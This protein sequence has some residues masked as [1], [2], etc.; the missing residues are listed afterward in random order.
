MR[1][2]FLAFLAVGAA[3]TVAADHEPQKS[4]KW[5]EL[6]TK[7]LRI[8]AQL[9]HAE[10]TNHEVLTPHSAQQNL[11]LTGGYTTGYAIAYATYLKTDT[12]CSGTPTQVTLRK[13]GTC[14]TSTSGGSTSSTFFT[15]DS[16]GFITKFTYPGSVCSG[17][18]ESSQIPKPSACACTAS[19]CNIQGGYSY[20]ATLPTLSGNVAASYYYT[21]GVTTCTGNY[22]YFNLY[23]LPTGATCSDSACSATDSSGTTYST[24]TCSAATTPALVPVTTGYLI[25][26]VMYDKTDKA[27]STPTGSTFIKLGGCFPIS[28]TAARMFVADSSGSLYYLYYASAT[29]AGTPTETSAAV[30]ARACACDATSCTTGFFYTTELPIP[31]VAYSVTTY[32]LGSDCT[33]APLMLVYTATSKCTPVA[34]TKMTL[35]DQSASMK[36]VCSTGSAPTAKPVLAVGSPT[37]APTVPAVIL[38]L[39]TQDLGCSTCKLSSWGAAGTPTYQAQFAQMAA[40]F[41]AS[42]YKALNMGTLGGEVTV[43]AFTQKSATR[44]Q[45]LTPTVTV[46]YT[47]TTTIRLLLLPPIFSFHLANPTHL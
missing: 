33:A 13:L 41:Q 46:A 5:L 10:A 7:N 24:A 37:M 17:S 45:L 27:C 3:S 35:N 23:S 18:S 2:L 26:S 20:A 38:I 4:W 36:M 39:A 22:E 12:T 28:A 47:G 31:T 42:I 43:T 32:S 44:R 25:Q 15:A 11:H 34:C 9:D 6:A 16:S 8:S 29:C 21:G 19:E 14:V 40:V 1:F 30:P